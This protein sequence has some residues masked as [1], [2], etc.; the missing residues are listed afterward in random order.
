MTI[1]LS[2]RE[3]ANL[4]ADDS[5]AIRLLRQALDPGSVELV[6]G[7]TVSASSLLPT[8]RVRLRRWMTDGVPNSIGLDDFV[9]TLERLDQSEVLVIGAHGNGW[10]FVVLAKP[11]KSAILGVVAVTAVRSEMP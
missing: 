4:A 11:D 10:N 1:Y 3:L 7:D 9:S 2:Q 6:S 5:S 8:Y